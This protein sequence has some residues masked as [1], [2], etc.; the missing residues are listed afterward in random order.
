[1]VL[2]YITPIIILSYVA[3]VKGFWTHEIKVLKQV[4]LIKWEI[5]LDQQELT[6]CAF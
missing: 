3:K 6:R 2:W 5:I 1:M 4:T